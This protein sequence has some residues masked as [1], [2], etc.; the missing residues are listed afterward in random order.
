[1][2]VLRIQ[3]DKDKELEPTHVVG[4]GWT[5]SKVANRNSPVHYHCNPKVHQDVHLAQIAANLHPD[6]KQW[7]V[8]LFQQSKYHLC[9]FVKQCCIWRG[10]KHKVLFASAWTHIILCCHSYQWKYRC[11]YL[12]GKSHNVALFWSVFI[13]FGSYW[14][15]II[16]MANHCDNRH[17]ELL[18]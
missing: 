18:L 6:T 7:V 8:N 11:S 16:E 4:D 15:K 13:C 12:T 9:S 2:W 3:R 10:Y 17:S 5:E 1:M 14:F